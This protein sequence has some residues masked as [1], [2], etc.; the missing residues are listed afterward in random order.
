MKAIVIQKHG[1]VEALQ[2]T[3]VAKPIAKVGEVVVKNHAIGVNFVDIQHRSGQNYPIN[4]PLIPGIEGAGEVE[5]V[6]E[7]VINLKV[8]DR[9]GYAGFMGGNYAEYTAVPEIKLVPIPDNVSFE[10]AASVLLQGMTAQILTHNV[11]PIQKNDVV[12]IHAAAGG[13]GLFL[14]QMAK[15]RGATVIGTVSTPEKFNAVQ[16][17]GADYIINYLQDDFE[18]EIL[19]W[20]NGAGV[21]VVYDSLGKVTFDKGLNVLRAMGHMVIYGLSSGAIAPFDINRLSGITG[22]RNKG[23]LFLTWATLSDYTS[24]REALLRASEDVLH[25]VANGSL[26]IHNIQKFPLSQASDAHQLIEGRKFIGKVLLIP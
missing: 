23:S 19:K 24:Q 21:N 7:G 26:I 3:E 17:L 15:R 16:S 18:A 11:Y 5:S 12:L 22:G 10:A 8:G 25:Q 4:L 9:V 2:L 20:T 14:V 13:V 6:G 1:G